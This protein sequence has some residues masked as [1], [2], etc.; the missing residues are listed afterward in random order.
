MSDEPK[1]ID[2]KG[3]AEL[4]AF[5]EAIHDV[6][7]TATE[8]EIKKSWETAFT[9]PKKHNHRK[10]CYLVHSLAGGHARAIQQVAVL[11]HHIEQGTTPP[12]IIDLTE[13]PL[14]IAEKKII[15]AS[16]IDQDH[17]RTFAEVGLIIK[18]PFENI[19]AMARLDLGTDFMSDPE[20]V[21]AELKV[22]KKLAT[23]NE[24]LEQTD[25][26]NEVVLTG[27][28]DA[29]NIEVV[30]FFNKMNKGGY[31]LNADMLYKLV[32]LSIKTGLPRVSIV[33]K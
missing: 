4:K 3:R 8:E 1:E 21:L 18:A 29:G 2:G 17:R 10:F 19:L 13:E 27:S 33:D 28:T 24:L 25:M 6:H 14:R 11:E 32:D 16:V 5:F 23:V 20:K 30:G 26:Y 9:N 12:P 7:T 31:P 15:S 22:R